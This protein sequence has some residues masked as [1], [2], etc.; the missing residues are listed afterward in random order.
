MTAIDW[1]LRPLQKYADFSGRAPRAEY[2]WFYLAYILS[3]VVLQV[4]VR[5][6]AKARVGPGEPARIQHRVPNVFTVSPCHD[7]LQKIEYGKGLDG[8]KTIRSHAAP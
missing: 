8:S 2:W 7:L 1:A 4:L 6:A 3:A 5:I